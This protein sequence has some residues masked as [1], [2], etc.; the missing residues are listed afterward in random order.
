MLSKHW[1]NLFSNTFV[2]NSYAYRP[3]K[4]HTKAIRRTLNEC[5]KKKNH[6]VLRL[7]IDN[8]FDTI[9]HHLLGARLHNLI[10][11]E[12]IGTTLFIVI[13]NSL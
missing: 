2:D 3:N 11:D 5:N 6:W 1:Q 12:E 13:S 10:P 7:D 9:N 4:G 8:Y